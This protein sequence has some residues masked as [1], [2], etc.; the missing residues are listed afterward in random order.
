MKQISL[1]DNILLIE[2]QK[3]DYLV[4]GSGFENDIETAYIDENQRFV[5]FYTTYDAETGS[6][7]HDVATISKN[8]SDTIISK[9]NCAQY[10]KNFEILG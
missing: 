9:Y 5:V 6:V 7:T 2:L 10:V 4:N 1:T 3:S 8:I